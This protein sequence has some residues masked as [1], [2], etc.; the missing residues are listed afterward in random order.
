MVANQSAPR[1]GI[2]F[3]PAEMYKPCEIY[4]RMSEVYREAYFIRKMFPNGE[5]MGVT[6]RV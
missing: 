6:Q 5:N 4:R 3:L 1:L 2:K